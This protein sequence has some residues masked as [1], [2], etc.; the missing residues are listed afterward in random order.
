MTVL[1]L[2]CSNLSLALRASAANF[3]FKHCVLFCDFNN[4]A[5]NYG[6]FSLP[7]DFSDRDSMD[8]NSKKVKN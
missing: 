8:S 6:V 2:R 7:R 3:V 5:I 1:D 4:M